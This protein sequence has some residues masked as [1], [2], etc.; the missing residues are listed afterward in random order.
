MMIVNPPWVVAGALVLV[1]GPAYL[2]LHSNSRP[3]HST[4]VKVHVELLDY[5]DR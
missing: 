4:E 1:G 3:K 2:V 5:I